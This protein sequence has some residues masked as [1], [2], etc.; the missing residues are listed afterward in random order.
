MMGIMVPKTCWA[1]HK[2]CNKKHLL[3][4]VGILFPHIN[5][6]ARSKSL[7]ISYIWIWK[8]Q[9]WEADQEIDDKMKWGRMEDQLVEKGGRKGYITE[10][11]GRSFWELQ[12]IV[13]CTCQWNEWMNVFWCT[14]LHINGLDISVLL[15]LSYDLLY[16]FFLVGIFILHYHSTATEKHC[17]IWKYS[18]LYTSYSCASRKWCACF[19]FG[20]SLQRWMSSLLE[21]QELMINFC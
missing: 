9:G 6:D 11:N 10:K 8:Q 19:T 4:L 15:L 5:D 1:S 3:H 14:Y 2:I 17:Q 13:F 7:Q 12:G 20:K 18:Y 21:T 16:Y